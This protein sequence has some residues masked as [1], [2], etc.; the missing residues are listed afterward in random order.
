M[1]ENRQPPK[2]RVADVNYRASSLEFKK[3]ADCNDFKPIDNFNKRAVSPDGFNSICR[4]CNQKK[5]KAYYQQNK[6][7]L[8]EAHRIWSLENPEKA[9]AA[10]SNWRKNNPNNTKQHSK[11]FRE[12][13]PEKAANAGKN[14]RKNNADKFNEYERNRNKELRKELNTTYVKRMICQGTNLRHSDI[15]ESMVATYLESV[16]LKRL[17]KKMSN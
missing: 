16:K 4:D 2:L 13:H 3:C 11:N 10:T 9:K 15:P 1:I 8:K 12:N 6:E 14:W 5:S 17:I 7:K